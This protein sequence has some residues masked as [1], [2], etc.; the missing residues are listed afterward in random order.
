MTLSF[1]PFLLPSFL[2]LLLSQMTMTLSSNLA[3]RIKQR[4][5]RRF[6]LLCSPVHSRGPRCCFL[7]C[8]HSMQS[9]MEQWALSLVFGFWLSVGLCQW[10]WPY[11][12]YLM[13]LCY[14]MQPVMVWAHHWHGRCWVCISSSNDR[15]TLFLFLLHLAS[16]VTLGLHLPEGTSGREGAM[17]LA[18]GENWLAHLGRKPLT[19]SSSVLCTKQPKPQCG[20]GP[21][22]IQEPF[23]D[24]EGIY[25]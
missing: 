19:S 1:R 21:H 10:H 7:L 5:P 3:L 11:A 8:F 14:E 4:F 22:W 25:I 20:N 12:L 9:P 17:S 23:L 13:I 6:P 16:L 2:P 18:T 15:L 24:S